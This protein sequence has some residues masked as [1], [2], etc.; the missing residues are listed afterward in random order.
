MILGLE[1]IRKLYT[2]I[3]E[4]QRVMCRINAPSIEPREISSLSQITDRDA[5]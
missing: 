2:C 1:Q 3:D 5:K 4:N